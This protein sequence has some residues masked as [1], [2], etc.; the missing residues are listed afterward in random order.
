MADN[1]GDSSQV[2]LIIYSLR[3]TQ[4]RRCTAFREGDY[5]RFLTIAPGRD[6]TYGHK[7]SPASSH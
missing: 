3:I 6:S 2:P 5:L 7:Y 1:D 4:S